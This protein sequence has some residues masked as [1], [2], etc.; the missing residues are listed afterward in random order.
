MPL[1]D[2]R[3]ARPSLTPAACGT[4]TVSNC[5]VFG[6][7]IPDRRPCWGMHSIDRRPVLAHGIGVA[8]R[9]T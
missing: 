3:R 1:R 5:G 6:T 4:F 2:R 9:G 8:V 7:P